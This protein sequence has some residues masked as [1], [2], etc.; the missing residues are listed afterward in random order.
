MPPLRSYMVNAMKENWGNGSV[1]LQRRDSF[2]L[3]F[4]KISRGFFVIA[5]KFTH[6]KKSINKA[7]NKQRHQKHCLYLTTFLKSI[8]IGLHFDTMTTKLKISWRWRGMNNGVTSFLQPVW[9]M[10]K[11]TTSSSVSR[12]VSTLFGEGLKITFSPSLYLHSTMIT[13]VSNSHTSPTHA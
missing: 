11:E 2:F 13:W 7:H 9:T 3:Y 12:E 5:L 8:R 10:P 1:E 4:D 6:K